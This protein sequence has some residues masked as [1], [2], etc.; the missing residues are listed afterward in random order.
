[1]TREYGSE[2]FS[3]ECRSTGGKGTGEKAQGVQRRVMALF[4]P[5]EV[6]G[7]RLAIV[8]TIQSGQSLRTGQKDSVFTH[9]VIGNH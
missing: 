1:M 6:V 4:G 5:S 3:S 9:I 8:A 7:V 2:W